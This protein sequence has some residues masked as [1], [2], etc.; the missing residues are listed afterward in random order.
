[1]SR[2]LRDRVRSESVPIPPLK[3]SGGSQPRLGVLVLDDA[4]SPPRTEA[5]PV[6]VGGFR[7]V[8][9]Y[10]PA[11]VN[12]NRVLLRVSVLTIVPRAAV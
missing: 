12:L 2:S 6:I 9:I 4:C 1:M 5:E 10:Q 8:R 3:S 11:K 7:C